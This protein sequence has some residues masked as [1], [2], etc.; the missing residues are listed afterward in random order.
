MLSFKFCVKKLNDK[1][2]VY[3]QQSLSAN[4]QDKDQNDYLVASFFGISEKNL[5]QFFFRSWCT[6]FHLCDVKNKPE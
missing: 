3:Y 2:S 6:I 1:L 5:E 4:Q